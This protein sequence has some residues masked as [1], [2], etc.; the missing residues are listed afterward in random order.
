MA[1]K[2]G[3]KQYLIVS[4]AGEIDIAPALTVLR[5]KCAPVALIAALIDATN[6]LAEPMN[7]S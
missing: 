7:P 1:D 3:E 6:S 5:A 4:C 2:L